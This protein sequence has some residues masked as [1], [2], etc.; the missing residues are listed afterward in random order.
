MKW[1]YQA[2]RF[3]GPRYL[4]IA[5]AV[6]R[7]ID[8]GELTNGT[9]LPTHRA[10]ADELELD[11]TTVTRAYSEIQRRGLIEA[12]VGQG[13]FVLAR[14]PDSPASLSTAPGDAQFIDLS[15]NFPAGAPALPNLRDLAKEVARN[16]DY[17]ALL[18]RQSDTGMVSHR[19]AGAAYL[20]TLG[21]ILYR[22]TH[23]QALK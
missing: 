18:G 14:L 21:I 8:D 6:T 11:V 19:A 23:L 3:K 22:H 5:D 20:E 4:A 15:H 17:G 12:R 7:A 10:L 9:K 16:L 1:I 2:K 13:T